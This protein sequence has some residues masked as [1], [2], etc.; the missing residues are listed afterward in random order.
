MFLKNTV[1]SHVAPQVLLYGGGSLVLLPLFHADLPE[2]AMHPLT[3]NEQNR[4]YFLLSHFHLMPNFEMPSPPILQNHCCFAHIV[5]NREVF[6]RFYFF[7]MWLINE[8]LHSLLIHQV[9]VLLHFLKSVLFF[10]YF[11]SGA[12]E[13]LLVHQVLA[14][15]VI[16][17]LFFAVDEVLLL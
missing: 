15:A 9:F 14:D 4:P 10:M 1:G 11:L 7:S 13:L 2:L 17:Q 5:I 16:D 6:H 8:V 12:W 3:L